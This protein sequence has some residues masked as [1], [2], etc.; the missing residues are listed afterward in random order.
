M[1]R[2]KMKAFDKIIG[3]ES[4]KE[5]LRQIC[6]IVKNREIYKRMGA[7][8]PKGILIN[9]EPGVGKSLMAHCLIE[10]CG[11]ASFVLRRTKGD[12]DFIREIERTFDEAM[13]SAPS[14]ILLDDLDKFARE[15]DSKEEYSVVQGCIDKVRGADVFIIAT[16]NTVRNMPRSLLRSGRFDRRIDVDA[17]TLDEARKIVEFYLLGKPLV[18]NV[19]IDDVCKML[20]GSSCAKLESIIND[21]AVYAAFERSEKIEMRHIVKATLRKS[22]TDSTASSLSDEEL[23]EIAYHEAGHAIISE[24][25]MEGGIGL[26]SLNTQTGRG[27]GGFMHKCK[28]YKRRAHE[29]LVLLGG[30]AGCELK[31]GR[32]AS[33]AFSDLE[34]ASSEIEEAITSSATMGSAGFTL[35]SGVGVSEALKD[36]INILVHGKLEE[37]LFKAKEMI[38]ANMALFEALAKELFEKK[39]LLAS[40]ISRIMASHTIVRVQIA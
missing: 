35:D 18:D 38:C 34:R 36:R 13:K 37:Y 14:I 12:G 2:F 20:A 3:Y 21:A 26:L 25:V 11:V 32:V 23:L 29:I 24:L 19:N 7:S 28:Q 17:P 22:Y 16:A 15:D 9:G 4:V 31:Y 8:M 6:D 39:T 33:G 40:D 1:R 27:R 5:E 10:E 30:K